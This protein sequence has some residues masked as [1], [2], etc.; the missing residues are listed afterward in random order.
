MCVP[1]L[2]CHTHV[3]GSGVAHLE[4]SVLHVLVVAVG[5]RGGGGTRPWCWCWGSGQGGGEL[6]YTGFI[7][8]R[9]Q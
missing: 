1:V 9:M 5:E 6:I 2:M 3:L 7:P 8:I 4:F